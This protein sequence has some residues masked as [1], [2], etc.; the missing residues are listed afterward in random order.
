M[1]N[2]S[3]GNCRLSNLARVS[4]RQRLDVQHQSNRLANIYT[5]NGMV[6]CLC[7]INKPGGH[8]KIIQIHY[9][10][11]GIVDSIDVKY[12]LGGGIDT[13]L[14]TDLVKPH[15]ELERGRRSRRG[16]D[17]FTVEAPAPAP[18]ASKCN[19]NVEHNKENSEPTTKTSWKKKA[20]KTEDA[21]NSSSEAQTLQKKRKKQATKPP[22]ASSED[23]ES[24]LPADASNTGGAAAKKK[25]QKKAPNEKVTAAAATKK[26]A[27]PPKPEN[28]LTKSRSSIPKFIG[29]SDTVVVKT[30][31]PLND[32]GT[33]DPSSGLR[34]QPWRISDNGSTGMSQASFSSTKAN[35]AQRTPS[36]AVFHNNSKTAD[37]ADPI[38]E[39]KTLKHVYEGHV[40]DAKEYIDYLMGSND[41]NNSSSKPKAQQEKQPPR[42]EVPRFVKPPEKTAEQRL[43]E[44]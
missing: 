44:E 42:P 19:K 29:T 4:G 9:S 17:F 11:V 12:T 28:K 8:G 39:R 2:R 1:G 41:K 3:R 35:K 34:Q 40:Q 14:E 27:A 16:R 31:S 36:P 32:G 33:G 38:V 5:Y 22:R 18:A 24:P 30:V 20:S 7:R 10:S 37:T 23:D 25:K 26:K 43:E 13:N 21:E 15:I 6:V